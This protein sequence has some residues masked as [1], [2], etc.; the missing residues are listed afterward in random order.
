MQPAEFK[1]KVFIY[2]NEMYRFALTYVK[3]G[4][5]AKDIVQDVLIKLWETRM[6]L[7]VKENLKAW[8]MALT[9]NKALDALKRVGRK[10]KT[11]LDGSGLHLVADEDL[12]SARL[13]HREEIQMVNKA[14]ENLSEKQRAVF[15]LRD[16]EGQ[17][18]LEIAETLEMDMNQ[19]K[20]NIHR[21][22]KA[23]RKN[24]EKLH[25]YGSEQ[26]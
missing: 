9:R 24:L 7:L 20:V 26:N 11:N 3:D 8:C 18:Y 22:R 12:P 15:Q 6:D 17:S 4:D 1:Q 5:E 2:R 23:I 14:L 13:Q 19:V 25:S 16:I 21:A 10:R